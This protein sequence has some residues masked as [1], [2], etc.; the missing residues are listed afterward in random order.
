METRDFGKPRPFIN[1]ETIEKCVIRDRTELPPETGKDYQ[2]FA[3]WS[4]EPGKK[5]LSSR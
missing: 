5:S 2:A 3:M 4:I 1:R